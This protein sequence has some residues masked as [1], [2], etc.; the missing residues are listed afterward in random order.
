VLLHLPISRSIFR[1]ERTYE[2]YS[3]NASC[4]LNLISTFY[5]FITLLILNDESKVINYRLSKEYFGIE[6]NFEI[7]DNKNVVELCRFRTV[8]HN[9]PIEIGRCNNTNRHNRICTHCNRN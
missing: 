7:L 4:A 1:F 5:S 2:G 8:N 6:V 9:L 3:R